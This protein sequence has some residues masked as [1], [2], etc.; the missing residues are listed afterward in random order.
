MQI[1]MPLFAD[2]FE[3]SIKHLFTLPGADEVSGEIMAAIHCHLR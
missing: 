2:S 3:P 1:F